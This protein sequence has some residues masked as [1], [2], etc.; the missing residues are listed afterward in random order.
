[1]TKTYFLYRQD[2]SYSHWPV[3][4]G[5]SRTTRWHR[6][7]QTNWLSSRRL[8]H[9]GD[10]RRRWSWAPEILQLLAFEPED[11]S[12]PKDSGSAWFWSPGLT[13]ASNGG[14][15]RPK[16]KRELRLIQGCNSG[17]NKC[18]ISPRGCS[19]VDADRSGR[20]W[21][22]DSEIQWTLS[23]GNS[24]VSLIPGSPAWFP[25]SKWSWGHEGAPRPLHD[26]SDG[27]KWRLPN[28]LQ[29][30]LVVVCGELRK[31]ERMR[32]IGKGRIRASV[33]RRF[34]GRFYRARSRQHRHHNDD[35][36]RDPSATRS[37]FWALISTLRLEEVWRGLGRWSGRVLE[38]GVVHNS[39]DDV[40]LVAAVLS[41]RRER[42]TK[43]VF[44]SVA[45]ERGG[46]LVWA[47]LAS[48]VCCGLLAVRPVFLCL[49]IYFL[50]FY[51]VFTNWI[52]ILFAGFEFRVSY[53]NFRT[54]LTLDFMGGKYVGTFSSLHLKY[55]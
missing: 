29:R 32:E 52:I 47:G 25:H 5:P 19:M 26:L 22:H 40:A 53:N 2:L 24:F 51:F 36:Y 15:L 3:G 10:H 37:S 27:R 39:D 28:E 38:S 55:N 13:P 16:C 12:E 31:M 54:F 11:Y 17:N 48:S 4:S 9:S 42:K 6:L 1:L 44:S 50:I 34:S 33:A 8:H 45:I 23:N 43:T 14:E 20:R 30:D 7:S 49:F 46:R 18:K 35:G 21:G 41:M